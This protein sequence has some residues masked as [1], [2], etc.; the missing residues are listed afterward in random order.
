MLLCVTVGLVF[1]VYAWLIVEADSGFY[2]LHTYKCVDVVLYA[3]NVLY[4]NAH[5]IT[6]SNTTSF[7][8]NG[9]YCL[10]AMGANNHTTVTPKKNDE[11]SHVD[12][13][14]YCG[15]DR[16]MVMLRMDLIRSG[17]ITP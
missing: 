17:V 6:K 8:T 11:I 9:V 14:S 12:Y 15:H 16:Y 13:D 7:N 1:V 5:I 2:W 10:I 4:S 3:R